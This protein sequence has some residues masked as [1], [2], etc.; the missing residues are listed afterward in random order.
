M[1]DRVLFEY[2]AERNIIFTEDHW[3]VRTQEDVDEFFTE[4][5]KFFESVGKKV[6]MISNIDELFVHAEIADYYGET[7]RATVGEFLLGF[8]R[9]GKNDYARMSVRT[10]SMKSKLPA[11]IY[12]TREEAI[13]AIEEMKKKGSESSKS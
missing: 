2:D 6:Y 10:S 12:N 1:A 11:N 13:A 3:D 7:A 4:Y 9:W 8:A 5:K